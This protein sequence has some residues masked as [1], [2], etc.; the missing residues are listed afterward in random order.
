[1]TI[2]RLNR[3]LIAVIAAITIIGAVVWDVYTPAAEDDFY[4]REVIRPDFN[5]A[6][7]T[8][9]GGNE[10]I[11]TLPQ[12]WESIKNHTVY[13]GRLANFLHIL[14]QPA[15]HTAESVLLGLCIGALFVLLCMCIRS[16]SGKM[17]VAGIIAATLSFWIILPWHDSF[18]SMAFQCNYVLPSLAMV[19]MMLL[20]SR[21]TAPVTWRR[22]ALYT[23]ALLCPWLHEGFGCTAIAYFAA[24]ALV[25]SLRPLRKT[26][27]ITVC[28]LCAGLA[29]NMVCGTTNRIAGNENAGGFTLQILVQV[30]TAL[31][32]SILAC[33]VAASTLFRKSA[34]STKQAAIYVPLLAGALAGVA[35]ALVFKRGDRV[36]WPCNIFCII[37]I[38]TACNGISMKQ[39]AQRLTALAGIAFTMLYAW[40]MAEQCV[41]NK[42][43]GDETRAIERMHGKRNSTSP[44]V[45]FTEHIPAETIPYRLCG[46]TGQPL[47]NGWSVE[48]AGTYLSGRT[49]GVL[50]LPQELEGLGFDEWPA[51]PGS[52]KLRG[53]YPMIAARD[54]AETRLFIRFGAYNDNASPVSKALAFIKNRGTTGAAD[55]VMARATPLRIILPDGTAVFR[56]CPEALPRTVAGRKFISIDEISQP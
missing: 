28:A 21:A 43:V 46:V 27:I 32:P 39:H 41:W 34:D 56:Y 2:Y 33:A 37:I 40:W 51:V 24:A 17:T 36:L 54:S 4:Y 6:T 20:Y 12:A 1:M 42:R 15:G 35:L 3:L 13:N 7:Q 31:W 22:A 23:L 19:G 8:W 50:V 30:G 5:P 16:F 38:C 47:E 49:G 29:L 26:A 45:F 10:D 18:Q 11:T 55:S 53:I 14:M 25:P 48:C 52:N 44:T 9:P